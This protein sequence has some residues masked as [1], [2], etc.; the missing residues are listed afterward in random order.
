MPGLRVALTKPATKADAF[1]R[2]ETASLDLGR[3]IFTTNRSGRGVEILRSFAPIVCK[4]EVPPRFGAEE[5]DLE[6]ELFDR[7][8]LVFSI[9]R[10]SSPWKAALNLRTVG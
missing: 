7:G 3:P 2:T 8:I 6:E 5:L 4:R 10:F 9:F 1:S